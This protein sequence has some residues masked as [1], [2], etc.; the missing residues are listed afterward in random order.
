MKTK[1]VIVAAAL[2]A[3]VA[4]A[5]EPN[6]DEAKVAP[7]SLEDP[8]TFADGRKLKD[9]SE[10]PARRKE[11]LDIFSSEMYGVEPPA[12][13]AVVT[14][15]REE[16]PTLAGLAIR[17]QYRMWFKADKSGPFIDW[18]LVLP[19]RIAGEKAKSVD[20]RT[21][22]E[23]R[24]KVPVVLML[25]YPGNHAV[26]DDAEVPLTEGGWF[27]DNGGSGDHGPKE[28]NRG[29]LRRSQLRTTVPAEFI[30][31]RG[32]AFLTACYAQVSPDVEV[33]R[34]DPEEL[35]YTH[36][37]ELW[38]KRDESRT[39]NTTALGAWAWALSRGLDL[40]ETIP[41]VDA[42]R[43]VA[44]GSSRLA[45]AALLASARDER[46]TVC[47]PNQ[48]GGGGVPLAKRN[49]GE[50]VST[51]MA[52]F[53]HWYCK[54]YAKYIDN[55]QAMKFD[56]HLLVAAI[57]PRSLLVQGFNA[58][59]FDA[60]GEWLSCRAASPAWEFL[61]KEGLPKGDFP[62][63]YDLSRIGSSFGYVRRGGQHGLSG[64]DWLWTLDFADKALGSMIRAEL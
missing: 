61:G 43:C 27:R 41:E 21:V 2:L 6:Y 37:F 45:K 14:E 48:T 39:D 58:R 16:G 49:F 32:Y 64:Y 3:S 17:R 33:R 34:G 59:W 11:I 46:F 51:E 12:P 60:K 56:Q 23:N 44:T 57:A 10:W 20:G 8:L 28:S 31:A 19:N 22:C 24:A 38:G 13:E 15:L 47:V 40:A 9:A 62:E 42:K 4:N 7:Y 55:E 26:L 1:F 50:N 25:N 54:A 5:R 18:L 52:S 36:V 53:P 63:N 30:A 29:V 35:A